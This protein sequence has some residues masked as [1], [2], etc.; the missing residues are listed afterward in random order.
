MAAF[1]CW[2][3]RLH[4]IFTHLLFAVG[5]E[6]VSGIFPVMIIRILLALIVV[7]SCALA[8][9]EATL[10]KALA[11]SVI[12]PG[13][14]QAEV[15]RFVESRVPKMPTVKSS[16]EWARYAE[17]MRG[18]TLDKVVFRGR[19]AEWRAMKTQV[20]WMGGIS[21]GKGYSIRKFRHEIVPG[22]WTAGLLYVPDNLSGR[23]PVVL[24]VNGHDRKN[25]KAAEAKQMRCINLAK[26]GMIAMNTEWLGMGQLNRPG[27]DH[28]KMPQINL[29][30]TSGLATFYLAMS[31]ALDVLLD[32]P[33]AD[34]ERVA[35]AG[36]SGGGWQTI[37][38]SALDP[39]VTLCNPVAGYSS[40]LTR[41]HHHS[42]LG[43]CEQTPSDLG[44]VTDYAHLTAML[45]PRPALL[46]FNVR[47]NCCF[48]SAHALPPLLESAGPIYR[49]FGAEDSLRS[50]VN[51]DPGTHNFLKDNRQQFYRILGD[52]FWKGGTD[53]SA[54]EISAQGEIKTVVELNVPLPEKNHDFNSLA[55]E[56][57]RDLPIDRS[58]GHSI[59]WRNHRRAK[60]EELVRPRRYDA[61]AK[62]VG[63]D[64]VDGIGV[65]WRRLQLGEDWTVPAVEFTP[66]AVRGTTI[67]VGDAGRKALEKEVAKLLEQGQ[68]VVALDPFYLG[69]SKVQSRDYLFALMVATVGE[70]PIGLQAGQLSSVCAWATRIFRDGPIGLH[71]VG[72]RISTAA[73]ISAAL[74]PLSVSSLILVDSLPSLR[75]PIE[76]DWH[77]REAPELFCF[78]LLEEFDM[79]Q[80]VAMVGA[81]RVSRKMLEQ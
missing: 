62:I 45:A 65:I 10:A 79:D 51:H 81:H 40:F 74:T 73:L 21:G 27:F 53:Y 5:A 54:A 43:D 60:L 4:H 22:M 68:R 16:A 69:E 66:S 18:D 72:P 75:T 34:P 26:R 6:R 39:R 80:L 25:G 67:L 17:K 61:T 28:Y 38:I 35:V 36:L 15:E 37:F 48:A 24:N 31:R 59:V 71:A 44:T 49:L 55:R 57:M 64:D 2:D 9:D 11:H 50:H 20:E 7:Q 8:A 29:C 42:D 78:G 13:V 3:F 33:H 19:A 30:G 58:I 47:D 56:L 23:V 76:R 32:H 77:V 41:V 46:T 14:P 12:D 1:F 52:F 63:R 70:R